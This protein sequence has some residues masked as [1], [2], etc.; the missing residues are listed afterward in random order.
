MSEKSEFS[1]IGKSVTPIDAWEKATG[2]AQFVTD[3][4][5]PGML[6][7]KIL[8]SPYAHARIV[9]IDTSKAKELPGVKAVVTVEDTPKVKFGPMASNED[10]YIFAKDKVRFIGEEVAAVA[11]VDEGTAEKALELIEVVYEELPAVFDLG[12]TMKPGAPVIHEDWPRNIAAEAHIEHGDVEQGF[13][14]SDLIIEETFATS[15]VYHAYMETMAVVVRPEDRNRVTMWLPIQIPNKVRLIYAKA[16]GL[17][18]EDIRVIK[19]FIGGAF[20]AKMETNLHLACAVL[21]QKT[22]RP[23]KIVNT[24]H[25]DFIAGNPRVPIQYWVKMGF[26]KDGKITAKQMRVIA[27]N[28]GRTVYAP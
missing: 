19:P 17:S 28:G 8:R 12:E 4:S 14:D 18:S 1:Y 13:A 11:A 9:R 2:R 20:G 24:R 16:L 25:E 22:K 15:Q 23:V 21:A 27:G 26:R 7:G 6:Y 5:L 3:L 10:W